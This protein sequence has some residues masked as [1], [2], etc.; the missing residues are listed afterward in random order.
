MRDLIAIGSIAPNVAQ[1]S[2]LMIMMN[3]LMKSV[4]LFMKMRAKV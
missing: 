3:V 4:T 1:S 2:M